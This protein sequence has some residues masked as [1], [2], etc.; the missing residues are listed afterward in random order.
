MIYFVVP[1]YNEELNIERQIRQTDAFAKSQ[2]L[3]Y[4][5]IIV[6]DGSSDR[7][8]EIVSAK[9][10]VFP[11]ELVSYQP[12]QGVGEA[13]RRGFKKALEMATSNDWIVTLEADGTSDLGI[14]K[15]LIKKI[16]N[17]CDVALASVYAK[18]GGIEGTTQIRMF[19]SRCA[20][21]LLYTFCP[22][23]GVRTY[24][25]FYRVYRP[26]ALREILSVYGDFYKEAGFACVVELLIRLART[27][28]SIEE[29]PMVLRGQHR[30]GQSKMKILKTIIG[31]L[32]IISRNLFANK[33]A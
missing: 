7:T 5:L 16:E 6:D 14:L 9:A 30:E 32:R 2:G 4:R 26:A 1:A 15:D 33:R 19:L 28:K 13:F 18:G 25:S 17:G 12:N 29:V 31:Y 23:K 11:C 21:R 3:T 10:S 24:S 20:N 27:G 8:A 22:I